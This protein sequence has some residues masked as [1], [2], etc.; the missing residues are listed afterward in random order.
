ME[1]GANAVELDVHRTVDGVIVCHHDPMV[2]HPDTGRAVAI[3]ETP[4]AA[5]TR[6]EVRG[7]PVPGLEAV[8]ALLAGRLVAYCELKG[9]GTAPGTLELLARSGADGAVHAFDH[10]QVAEARRLAPRVPRGVLEAS[11]PLDPLGALHSVEGRDIWRHWEH[12]DEALVTAAHAGGARVIAWT[13]NDP[14]VVERFAS[15]GVDGLCTDDVAQARRI[16]G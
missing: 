5:I 15:W 12:V 13:V 11:Y 1:L 3:S 6:V 8:L 14:R 10:R 7:E 16:L 4:A 2:T 9:A